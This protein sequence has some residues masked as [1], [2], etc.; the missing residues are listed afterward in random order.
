MQE[1]IGNNM[2]DNGDGTFTITNK[3]T[4]QTK[5]VKASELPNYG[6]AAP[7]LS[8]V[9]A[10]EQPVNDALSHVPIVGGL[11]SAIARPAV[12]GAEVVAQGL[13][14][15]ITAATGGTK[16]PQFV[17]PQFQQTLN[18][19]TQAGAEGFLHPDA[20]TQDIGIEGG[21][22]V[23]GVASY[24][25]TGWGVK[26][27]GTAGALNGIS[28]SE[29][30]NLSGIGT[31]A[32]VG[33]ALA[34]GGGKA[35][36]YGGKGAAKVINATTRAL[37]NKMLSHAT[38]TVQN[39][40]DVGI[41]RLEA[42]F[43]PQ[44]LDTTEGGAIIAPRFSSLFNKIGI[45]NEASIQKIGHKLGEASQ[46][47]E[48]ELAN[49]LN[50]DYYNFTKADVMDAMNPILDDTVGGLGHLGQTKD[51]ITGF[52]D[53]QLTKLADDV[54]PTAGKAATG[55]VNRSSGGVV[56]VVTNRTGSEVAG[57]GTHAPGQIADEMAG[58]SPIGL[59]SLLKLKRVIGERADWGD[60]P[61]GLDPYQQL[62]FKVDE[63]IKGILAPEDLAK[64][65]QIMEDHSDL[66]KL[67]SRYTKMMNKGKL[68]EE[69][70]N[71][72]LMEKKIA[73]KP[74]SDNILSAIATIIGG[75]A[76][77]ALGAAGGPLGMTGGAISL[78]YGGQAAARALLRDPKALAKVSQ[79]LSA[80]AR[81]AD[82]LPQ[83]V[84]TTGNITGKTIKELLRQLNIRVQGLN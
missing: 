48:N 40:R 83:A 31:D 7:K 51:E 79:I 10:F 14:E 29:S 58:Q 32:L 34:I 18:N 54:S 39:I 41:R 9:G 28:D 67:K 49:T 69:V 42:L 53:R 20:T 43:G 66:I 47:A 37:P 82:S 80:P 6:L 63:M 70:F 45:A 22:R 64:Y 65:G 35:L 81:A 21:K 8:N 12:K 24:L 71:P 56:P 13:G 60:T 38:E 33:G 77:A 25:P 68:P 5:R 73:E 50:K 72:K 17:S 78:G 84:K 36:Q 44:I 74:V 3:K 61:S 76:G 1:E 23:A 11:L 55:G 59:P 16:A 15:G 26:A 19:R 30:N 75:G 2:V 52:L 46:Q 62:Y 57:S 27:L 4:A